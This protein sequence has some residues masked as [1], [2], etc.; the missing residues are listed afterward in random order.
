MKN[1]VTLS[2]I[3]AEVA[4]QLEVSQ[5]SVEKVLTTAFTSIS[6]HLETGNDVVLKDFARLQIKDRA[7]RTVSNP[8]TK[9][10]EIEVPPRRVIK[11]I[12]RGNLKGL[13][14][15]ALDEEDAK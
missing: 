9:G 2:V 14:S 4:A 12:P 15:E 6:G 5:V 7:A 1:S 13:L 10:V 11:F 3:V 8:L